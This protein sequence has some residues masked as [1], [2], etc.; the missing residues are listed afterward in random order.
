M[1]FKWKLFIAFGFASAILFS[2]GVLSYRRTLQADEDQTW[3]AHTQAVREQLEA[4]LADIMGAENA[5]RGFLITG[6]ESYI[7]SYR[8]SAAAIQNDIAAA[9][10]L[11]HDNPA[12]QLRL[13]KLEP[14][15]SADLEDLQRGLRAP[16]RSGSAT[17]HQGTGPNAHAK[18]QI[19]SLLAQMKSEE[20][21]L[22]TSRMKAVSES[23]R[24]MKVIIV[25]GYAIAFALLLLASFLVQRE[26]HNR[27]KA[28][29]ALLQ[30]EQN[31]RSLIENVKD[32][33]IFML[34]SEGRVSAWNTG[35]ERIKGYRAEE[36]IGQSFAR[37]YTQE[38]RKSGKPEKVLGIAATRGQ[39]EDEGWRVRKDGSRFWASIVIT[40]IRDDAGRLRGF[41]KIT[42]DITERRRADLRFRQ[43][44][45]AAPDAMLVVNQSGRI[46]LV[47]AQVEKVFGYKREELLNQQVELLMPERFRKDH[48]IRR[49]AYTH[50][51]RLRPMGAGLELHG[52]RKD[53]TEFPV[54]ISLSPLDTAE[55]TLISAAIRDVT[56]RTRAE[57]KFRQ[58]LEAAPDAMVVSNQSGE[59]VLVNAQVEKVFGYDRKE[60]LGQN[61]ELLMP[62]RFRRRHMGHRSDFSAHPRVRPMDAGFELYGLRKD[63][64]EFPAEISLSPLQTETGM[65][66]SSAIRDITSRKQAE[67]E[68]IRRSLE[69]EAANKELESFSYSVSHDLRA[70]LRGIDGF[71]QALLED[72][73]DTLDSSAKDHL[74]R[75]RAGTQR[76]GV[77]IDDLLNLSRITRTEIRKEDADLSEI[78]RAIIADLRELQP[79]RDVETVV[80]PNLRSYSDPRLMRVV[81]ENLLS[82]A[83]KFTSKKAHARIEFGRT[84]SNG[85]SAFYVKDDGAGFDPAFAG[86]LFGA[87]QRLHGIAEFPGTG[88]GLATV[89]RIIHRHG[90]KIWAESQ[91]GQGATFY[92]TL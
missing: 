11:T 4:A 79:K 44:L 54:E 24:Q 8:K 41:S 85:S 60:L 64:T 19:P 48:V 76:M 66:V 43:L 7:E 20:D 73:G 13:Q 47:N 74:Q 68:I 59:I 37:F 88:I 92:F 80:A 9:L 23:S 22:L 10:S 16:R 58:L 82:N 55:G 38:D 1:S 67:R 49:D 27:R 75:I 63:G 62:E 56:E 84:D 53:G 17:L 14:L 12:Q 65:L 28:E 2:V 25:F 46:V 70:P 86:R 69:L 91:P 3:V 87:F 90:G 61:I 40:A 42:R 51:P 71:S 33:A 26:I 52:L 5:Q 89:Q 36:I 77:L 15:I 72:C 18:T 29:Q 39:V 78:G 45:E 30:N 21:R 34:D 35:A 81:L 50:N 31:S 32:H 6:D 83:W 57:Q